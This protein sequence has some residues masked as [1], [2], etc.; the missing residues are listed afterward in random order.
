MPST[1]SSYC[2]Q[3]A[4]PRAPRTLGHTHPWEDRPQK[5][6]IQALETGA[7]PLAQGI[8]ESQ[9]LEHGLEGYIWALVDSSQSAVSLEE[10][11]GPLEVIAQGRGPSCLG[12]RVVLV[13][14]P[15]LYL[16]LA[17]SN[18]LA[19]QNHCSCHSLASVASS[20]HATEIRSG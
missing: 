7:G 10:G 6:P 2:L 1:S 12:Q 17:N 14:V 19:T 13:I 8:L 4:I 11:Q 20:F 5:R 16:P 9:D 3:T 18:V 15:G